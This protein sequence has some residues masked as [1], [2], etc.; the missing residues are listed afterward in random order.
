[1]AERSI[2]LSPLVLGLGALAAAIVALVAAHGDA[3]VE[4]VAPIVLFDVGV[5]VILATLL[6]LGGD[7]EDDGLGA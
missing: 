3:P 7:G 4:W 5:G 2:R 1:M 6:H